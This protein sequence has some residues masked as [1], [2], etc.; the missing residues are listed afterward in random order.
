M[1]DEQR[2][3]R[4]LIRR[5]S[6]SWL[7]G[8]NGYPLLYSFALV[9]DAF[10]DAA[11]AAA[12]HRFPGYYSAESLPLIGAERQMRRGLFETDSS[13][14]IRL[15]RWWSVA[16]GR[17]N[18]Y[19]LLEQL[20]AFH[21]PEIPEIQVVYRSGRR[22]ALNTAGEVKMD[23]LT[24]W[25]PNGFPELWATYTVLIQT[26]VYHLAPPTV[27]TRALQDLRSLIQDLNAAHCKGVTLVLADGAE[28]WSAIPPAPGDPDTTSWNDSSSWDS[29]GEEPLSVQFPDTW[30]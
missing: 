29:T 28:L 9:M 5:L 10:L 1:N 4:D 19:E 13:Y 20:R 17:G 27:R 11:F 25:S 8:L 21:L 23:D 3:L 6:P 2:T 26:D 30:T 12:K 22:F 14:A 18:P 16:R 7:Q 15:R 24:G